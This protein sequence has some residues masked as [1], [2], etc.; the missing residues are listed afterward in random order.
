MPLSWAPCTWIATLVLVCGGCASYEPKPLRPAQSE[1]DLR[2]RSLADPGLTSFIT[3]R[4]REQSGSWTLERLTL[5]AFYFHP[6]LELARAHAGVAQAGI[7]RA[8]RGR[9]PAS[10]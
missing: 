3:S 2:S 7:I 4:V 5:A 8:A 9:I 1:A 6:D 10:R